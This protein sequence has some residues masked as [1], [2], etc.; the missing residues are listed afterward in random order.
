[1]ARDIDDLDFN[2]LRTKIIEVIGA[3][4]GTYGYGQTIQSNSV[5]EGNIITSA[6]WDGLRYD[7]I[8]ILIHQNGVTPSLI[9]V[10]KGDV[11]RQGAG[12][13]LQ[14]YDRAIQQ[15]R[16]NRFLLAPSQSVVSV[17]TSRTYTSSWSTN[18]SMTAQVFFSSAEEARYFFN[19]GG[20]IRFS[21]L[22]TGGSVTAQNNA[23]SNVLANSG[24][25]EFGAD[26]A[27]LNFY[28]LKNFYQTRFETTLSTPYSANVYRIEALCNVANNST[29][30]ATSITFRITWQDNYTD[31]APPFGPSDL[32]DG[33]LS[34]TIEEVK[35]SGSL[36]PSGSFAITSPS[37]TV[38]VITA[39]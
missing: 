27:N 24:T 5:V 8:N 3:G 9:R 17:V 1:M 36:Q 33:T 21:S 26:T 25:I 11:I 32:V 30:S 38:S 35:A 39:S 37:Y 20:K 7:L 6:Q 14:E 28:L 18:A 10:V 12:D 16:L 34:M 19:S 22:R 31:T 4:Y 2:S 13:P 23:W 15:A 29:G